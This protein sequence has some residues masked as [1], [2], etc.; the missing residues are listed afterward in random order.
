LASHAVK[1]DHRGREPCPHDGNVR[2]SSCRSV[3]KAAA[4]A[5]SGPDSPVPCVCHTAGRS[6]RRADLDRR[7]GAHPQKRS[8]RGPRRRSRGR[9]RTHRKRRRSSSPA[10]RHGEPC[11]CSAARRR[12]GSRAGASPALSSGS[13]AAVVGPLTQA[14]GRP[15]AKRRAPRQPNAAPAASTAAKRRSRP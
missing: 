13:S 12:G 8:G 3:A 2:G 9:C 6:G 15:A 5:A 11:R 4:A 1:P 14:R 7:S 10:R